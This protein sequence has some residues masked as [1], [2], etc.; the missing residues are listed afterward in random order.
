MEV[1]LSKSRLHQLLSRFENGVEIEMVGGIDFGVYFSFKGK[2][3]GEINPSDR[4]VGG[5]I[6]RRDGF[7]SEALVPTRAELFG[8][9]G[10]FFAR[11]DER[12]R[13]FERWTREYYDGKGKGK[14]E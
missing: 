8:R 10:Q 7:C 3:S 2:A 13:K 14:I 9:G 12:Q 5:R 6:L 11:C 4:I 1:A